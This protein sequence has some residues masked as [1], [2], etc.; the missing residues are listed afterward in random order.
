MYVVPSAQAAQVLE[1]FDIRNV[2]VRDWS[3]IVGMSLLA[4]HLDPADFHVTDFTSRYVGHTSLGVSLLHHSDVHI[5]AYKRVVFGLDETA[6]MHV[7]VVTRGKEAK[8]R[9][10][11]DKGLVRDRTV[12]LAPYSRSADLLPWTLWTRLAESLKIRGYAVFTNVASKY[13]TSVPGTSPLTSEIRDAAD[14]VE[15]AGH[16]IGLRSGLCDIV[17]SARCRR[18]FLYASDTFFTYNSPSSLGLP[19]ASDS[20]DVNCMHR[21][22]EEVLTDILRHFPSARPCPGR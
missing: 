10:L 14:T 11:R 9:E 6:K 20:I 19:S 1:F 8:A 12:I 5:E 21:S 17:S 2:I 13:E 15:F 22:D 16:F 3:A 7:P 18:I 4:L